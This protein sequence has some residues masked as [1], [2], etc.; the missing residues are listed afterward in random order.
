MPQPKATH[1][2]T[3]LQAETRALIESRGERFCSLDA[4]LHFKNI[5]G[6]YGHMSLF[7]LGRGELYV[8]DKRDAERCDFA[9]VE[10]LLAAGW[11]ID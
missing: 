7:D 9:D 11:A 10:A 2:S 4:N 1:W 5:D 6:R 3:S 8:I